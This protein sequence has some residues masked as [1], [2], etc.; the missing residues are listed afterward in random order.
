[1]SPIDIAKTN[2]RA[3][4]IVCGTTLRLVGLELLCRHQLDFND[5][6]VMLGVDVEAIQMASMLSHHYKHEL[7]I[8]CNAEP[9]SIQDP[10]WVDAMAGHICDNVVVEIVE[11]NDLL[12]T[13]SIL[14][15]LGHTVSWIRRL[16]G[17][18][19]LD[20][21]SGSCLESRL[22]DCLQPE[23]LKAYDSDG[24]KFLQGLRAG[25]AIVMERIESSQDAIDAVNGGATELQGYWCDV[26]LKHHV[27]VELTPPGVTARN[28]RQRSLSTA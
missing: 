3:Q 19:A 12:E 28:N 16:G 21:V 4:P 18:I 5:R 13:K 17:L 8:H 1:M 23:I 22:I 10:R 27:P 2:F 11:R 25:A 14:R 24:L 26:L 9:T 15:N 6:E 20:D 7:R